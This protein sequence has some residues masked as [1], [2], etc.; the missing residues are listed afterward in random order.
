MGSIRLTRVEQVEMLDG[1]LAF[2]YQ[3]Y[4]ES[5]IWKMASKVILI[6]LTAFLK[7]LSWHLFSF[8]QQLAMATRIA[9]AL[10]SLL[11]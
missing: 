4:I 2:E 1:K 8:D 3:T 5:E 10:D 11:G 6:F 9:N 7:T